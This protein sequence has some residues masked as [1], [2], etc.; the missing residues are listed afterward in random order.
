MTSK[1]FTLEFFLLKNN[2]TKDK[3]NVCLIYTNCLWLHLQTYESGILHKNVTP[4]LTELNSTKNENINYPKLN[5][6]IN[7]KI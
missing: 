6:V 1:N 4:T 5:S 7:A 2:T 3:K